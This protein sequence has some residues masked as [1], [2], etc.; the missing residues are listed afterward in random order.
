MLNLESRDTFYQFDEFGM[1]IVPSDQ[2]WEKR[3]LWEKL[4]DWF[5]KRIWIPTWSNKS[6]RDS[7]GRTIL[8]G[9][10]YGF[11]PEI[12]AAIESCYHN[13]I[14]YRH[15]D[16]DEVAS[17]DHH[18]YFYIYRMYTGQELPNFPRM[19]GMNEWMGTLQGLKDSEWWYY[20]WYIPGAR[21]GNFWL[22]TCRKIGKIKPERDNNWWVQELEIIS[23]NGLEVKLNRTTWQKLWA[24][25]IFQTMPAYALHVKALQI[26]V[27]PESE[28]REKI[29]SILLRRVAKRN[30][31]VRLL[32]GDNTV[33]H[34]EVD[35]YPNITNFPAGEYFDESAR[36]DN[37]EMTEQ[38]AE[39]NTYE[40]DLIIYLFKTKNHEHQN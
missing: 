36:R 12:I 16:H 31:L 19:R 37:V 35:D 11:T 32:L 28:K 24:W 33:T 23:Y 25:I 21:L 40:R 7:L 20:F 6:W 2:S 38:E 18:S 5:L 22:K 30:L 9:L 34:Q 17:R 1:C 10:A 4:W 39:F 14:L 15:P 13:G 3:S 27:M 26:Y 8:C 29:K